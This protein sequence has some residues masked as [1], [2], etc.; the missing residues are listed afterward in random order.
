MRMTAL[1][2]VSYNKQNAK[3]NARRNNAGHR[4]YVRVS[5]L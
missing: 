1:F 2:V 5:F 4:I 3:Q